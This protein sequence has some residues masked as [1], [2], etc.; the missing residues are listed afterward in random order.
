M[1]SVLGAAPFGPATDPTQIKGA[2]E[3]LEDA[4]RILREIRVLRHFNHENVSRCVQACVSCVT[5]CADHR[6]GGH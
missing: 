2:F 1:S 4:K 3:D 5:L 6:A